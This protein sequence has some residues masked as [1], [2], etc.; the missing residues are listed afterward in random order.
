MNAK[1]RSCL[2]A[3]LVA[4]ATMAIVVV[5][6][7]PNYLNAKAPAAARNVARGLITTPAMTVQGCKLSIIPRDTRLGEGASRS[8]KAAKP[9]DEYV[10]RIKAENTTDRAVHLDMKVAVHSTS[11][12][13]RMSRAPVMPK[14]SWKG[15][16][17]VSLD[18][19][20]NTIIKVATGKKASALGA[21]LSTQVTVDG[22]HLYGSPFSMLH[23]VPRRTPKGNAP[24]KAIKQ[25]AVKQTVRAKVGG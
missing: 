14:V 2:T 21:L 7:W 20:E 1:I 4:L 24:V 13:S 15:E 3:T 10:V 18:A 16:Y 17:P 22:K 23:L 11:F 12:S 8:R 25:V 5:T 19:G 6:N 9:D